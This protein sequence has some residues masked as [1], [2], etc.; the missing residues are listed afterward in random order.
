MK[1]ANFHGYHIRKMATLVE[2]TL[3]NESGQLADG[4]MLRKMVLAVV[5]QNPY[6]GGISRGLSVWSRIP[7]SSARN[8]A[9]G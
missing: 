4:G 9:A 1:K 3:A 5:L 2:D 7:T 8:S 6:A